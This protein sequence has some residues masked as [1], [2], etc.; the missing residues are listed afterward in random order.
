MS[1][2]APGYDA[3]QGKGWL[4][5]HKWLLLRRMTQLVVMGVFLIGPW[6]GWWLVKGNL[7]SSKTLEVLPLTDPFM[8]LQLL[9]ARHWPEMEALIGAAIVLG[10]YLLV[11]GRVFCS[12]VC[13]MNVVTD[14]ASWLRRRLG[15]KGGRAPHESTRRWLLGAILV[16]TALSGSLVWEWVNPVSMLQR[17]LVFGF[18]AA[19][20]VVLVVFAYDVLV[21]SR[22]WCGHLCPMGVFY[23]VLG[24]LAVWRVSAPQRSECN[25]C[26]DCFAVCPEPQVIRPALKAVGQSH[27]LILD[28]ACTN[29]GRCVDVCSQNVFRLTSRFNRSEK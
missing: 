28:S 7:S 8:L 2:Q 16:A 22:G 4:R 21:A 27:P 12:W 15:L 24:K 10:F 9:A 5:A 1:A 11:G 26:M 14:A 19:W 29:C 25:D 17:G 3:V 23:G 6:F 13:P 20:G 18:G